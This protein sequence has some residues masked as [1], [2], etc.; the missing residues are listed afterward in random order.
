MRWTAFFISIMMLSQS[1]NF[2]FSDFAKIGDLIEHAEIHQEEYG[3]NWVTFLSKHYGALKTQ[4]EEQKPINHNHHNDLP[5]HCDQHQN[6][7]LQLIAPEKTKI[8]FER[9][10]FGHQN[11]FN[12]IYIC[13]YNSPVLSKIGQPPKKA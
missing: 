9:P 8:S 13:I 2:H 7:Q 4:H 3:D 5:F 12:T 10:N 11:E 1:I 6:T